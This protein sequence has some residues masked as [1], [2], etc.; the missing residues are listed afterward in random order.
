[1]GVCEYCESRILVR[2]AV[3]KLK[4]ELE[5]K[6]AVDGIATIERLKA[7]ARRSFDVGQYDN[8][9]RDWNRV[10]EI[11]A[12]DHES[13]W[14]QVRC[15]MA[16]N[17]TVKISEAFFILES[18]LAYAPPEKR[19]EYEE[20]IA[21]HNANV[22]VIRQQEAEEKRREAEENRR[23]AE[24]ERLKH[25]RSV[26]CAIGSL[27]FVLPF[28]IPALVVDLGSWDDN[29]VRIILLSFAVVLIALSIF[30]FIKPKK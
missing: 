21:A 10:T 26:G 8:A 16:Q 23:K 7:N 12:T 24:E 4:V 25:P 22:D 1:M 6:V 29:P 13:Y 11:D 17:P 30:F 27:V 14:G 18:A 20:T 15:W 28:L 19:R 3:A 2:E 5:G 9:I